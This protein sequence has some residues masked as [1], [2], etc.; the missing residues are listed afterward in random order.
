M[1]RSFRGWLTVG[2]VSIVSNIAF[3]SAARRFPNGPVG[4]LKTRLLGA[5]PTRSAS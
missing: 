2:A 1:K 3:L 5:G 4:Q